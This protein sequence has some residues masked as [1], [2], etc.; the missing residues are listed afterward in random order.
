M[1]ASAHGHMHTPQE[2][3][4]QSTQ[5]EYGGDP[6]E[7]SAE[8]LA[9]LKQIQRIL[10]KKPHLRASAQAPVES[11]RESYYGGG[12]TDRDL[13]VLDRRAMAVEVGLPPDRYA[14]LPA[15][16][17]ER[18]IASEQSYH[19]ALEQAADTF[20]GKK[21]EKDQA[22]KATRKQRQ[23]ARAVFGLGRREMI[24]RGLLPPPR[25]V[26]LMGILKMFGQ[27]AL[28][29]AQ[30]E[31][32]RI[33]QIRER[34]DQTRRQ[35][36][37]EKTQ[38]ESGRSRTL[39]DAL[40][41]ESPDSSTLANDAAETIERQISQAATRI[42]ITDSTEAELVGRLAQALRQVIQAEADEADRE[43]ARAQQQLD[44][45]VAQLQPHL[46]AAAEIDGCPFVSRSLLLQIQ[47]DLMT[48]VPGTALAAP[49]AIPMTHTTRYATALHHAHS[50][51][52]RLRSRTVRSHGKAQ[53]YTLEEILAQ[54]HAPLLIA[55]SESSIR[56]AMDEAEALALAQYKASGNDQIDQRSRGYSG[57]R[58]SYT[59]AWK[60]GVIQNCTAQAEPTYTPFEV[61][62]TQELISG[63]RYG[64]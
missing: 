3:L 61:A 5:G 41:A 9:D 23:A 60:D 26:V 47:T 6:T 38:L 37:Q 32:A 24:E 30:A 43:A 45:H 15:G 58:T 17:E 40:L 4:T 22:A 62:S 35:A 31:A 51:A 13:A 44:A 50:E 25:R 42:Q 11:Y 8:D 20:V 64:S 54:S 53:G 7:F 1:N 14:P 29:K 46:D 33:A 18:Y 56:Y 28:E 49:I 10:K 21:L 48:K 36:I 57:T 19:E 12:L 59:L 55:P 27:T 39:A 34:L 16:I 52:Q 63:P 2:K